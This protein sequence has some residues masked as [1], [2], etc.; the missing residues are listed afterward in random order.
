ML[1]PSLLTKLHRLGIKINTIIYIIVDAEWKH[2]TPRT[3][4]YLPFFIFDKQ[5]EAGDLQVQNDALRDVANLSDANPDAKV[6]G[7][8]AQEE[9]VVQ[10][11]AAQLHPADHHFGHHYAG[12]DP[13]Q[14]KQE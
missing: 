7:V 14:V 1:D 2:T 5:D 8:V 13:F 11:K 6:A 3:K 10:L 9:R 4:E 12:L